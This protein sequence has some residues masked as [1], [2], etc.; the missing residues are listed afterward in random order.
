[1]RWQPCSASKL[2]QST[3][4]LSA[5]SASA[6]LATPDDQSPAGASFCLQTTAS[7]KSPLL[8]RDTNRKQQFRNQLQKSA[9]RILLT[10]TLS[11]SF[12]VRR[13]TFCCDDLRPESVDDLGLQATHSRQVERAETS[14]FGFLFRG[15]SK[16]NCSP[17]VSRR[18][19]FCRRRAAS[20]F[21]PCNRRVRA[22]RKFRPRASRR[23]GR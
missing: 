3:V 10:A 4:C 18:R 11:F 16:F 14:F 21:P 22:R 8:V 9:R 7:N 13:L 23:C 20:R 15:F 5:K 12:Q 1:M 17:L 19:S 6:K 2:P